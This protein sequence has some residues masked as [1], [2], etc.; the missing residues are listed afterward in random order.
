MIKLLINCPSEFN[1]STKTLKIAGGIESLSFHL[2]KY[3]SNINIDVTLSSICNKTRYANNVL[4]L[5]INLI[6]K[7]S[8]KYN[9]DIIIS[10][11]DSSIFSYFSN[12]K[13]ILWLHNPLQ[14]EKS[15]RKKTVF[16]YR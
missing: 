12:S 9:F 16:F 6:K 15:I 7:K 13:K 4:N 3:L 14:I 2:A 11:N 1:L 10:S 5:P 8:H